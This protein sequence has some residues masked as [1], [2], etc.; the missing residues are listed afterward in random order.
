MDL[1]ACSPASTYSISN[2]QQNSYLIHYRY[3][4]YNVQHHRQLNT[5]N[6]TGTLSP[7]PSLVN[8]QNLYIRT[9]VQSS[10][11]YQPSYLTPSSTFTSN[12]INT[13]TPN[14][15]SPNQSNT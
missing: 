13:H 6:Q 5:P 1:S 14:S 10:P 11:R 12:S 7:S 15:Q 8:N 9:Y 4:H 2:N 3:H